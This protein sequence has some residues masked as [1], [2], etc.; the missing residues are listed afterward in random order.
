MF[1]LT[2]FMMKE[3]ARAMVT[4]ST[5]A[6][7]LEIDR[8]LQ[9]NGSASVSQPPSTPMFDS[10]NRKPSLYTHH[11]K[12]GST[13]VT[14]NIHGVSSDLAHIL[15]IISSVASI[16]RILQNLLQLQLILAHPHLH[17]SYICP[18]EIPL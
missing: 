7:Q 4:C 2:P 12:S 8:S 14:S 5:N 18:L 3:W 10:V 9:Y 15:Q 1:P 11:S 13:F 6:K 17:L 16:A